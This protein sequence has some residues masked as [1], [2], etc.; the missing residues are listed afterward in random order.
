MTNYLGRLLRRRRG[1]EPYGKPEDVSSVETEVQ[2]LD[3][4]GLPLAPPNHLCFY[5][6]IAKQAV[7]KYVLLDRPACIAC[8]EKRHPT[9]RYASA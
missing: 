4:L 5:C 8:A 9:A 6:A 1:A 7:A 3:P 2:Q